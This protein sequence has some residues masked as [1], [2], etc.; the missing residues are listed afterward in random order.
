MSP[1]GKT[2]RIKKRQLLAVRRNS[3]RL[4]GRFWRGLR[5]RARCSC[6]QVQTRKR[7]RFH[8]WEPW[9][10]QMLSPWRCLYWSLRCRMELRFVVQRNSGSFERRKWRVTIVR[11][12]SQWMFGMLHETQY[13]RNTNITLSIFSENVAEFTSGRQWTKGAINRFDKLRPHNQIKSTDHV[14]WLTKIRTRTRHFTNVR[15]S[16]RPGCGNIKNNI[17]LSFSTIGI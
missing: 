17:N 6:W 3:F 7:N 11:Q 13:W 14:P 9:K 10:H 16:S 8:F 5:R 2:F 4:A 1:E 12:H 15:Y